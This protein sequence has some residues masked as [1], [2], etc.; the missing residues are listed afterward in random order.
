M[1][2]EHPLSDSINLAFSTPILRRRWPDSA[3]VNE[4]LS[5]AIHEK[6]HAEPTAGR[7]LIGG[8]HSRDDLLEWPYPEIRV[9][10]AWTGPPTPQIT[11]FPL[12]QLPH[13]GPLHA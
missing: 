2:P 3:P 6:E 7:S 5:R 4:G 10:P 11:Q 9:F 1:R 12:P 13:K 8:W